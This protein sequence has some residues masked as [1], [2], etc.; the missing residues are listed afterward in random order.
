[1]G[2]FRP[3]GCASAGR[4]PRAR[5][6]RARPAGGG[7]RRGGRRSRSS[8][9]RSRSPCRPRRAG[10]GAR[11]RPGGRRR[12]CRARAA[13]GTLAP[14]A[15]L[16]ARSSYQPLDALAA[17]QQLGACAAVRS[18]GGLVPSSR[19]HRSSTASAARRSA[20]DAGDQARSS[21]RAGPASRRARPGSCGTCRPAG[22]MPPAARS[23]LRGR[24]PAAPAALESQRRM[25]NS[26]ALAR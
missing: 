23:G 7:R 18:P 16:A 9:P 15:R 13:R 8:A 10:R 20:A 26:T 11:R 17:L 14:I 19:C 6:R 12:P 2:G 25:P 24:A 1:M 22:A 5:A 4:W 21:P 3:A